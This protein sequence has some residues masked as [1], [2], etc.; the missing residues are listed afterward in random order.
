[1][2]Q[3]TSAFRFKDVSIG[4]KLAISTSL[5]MVIMLIVGGLGLVGMS[6]I[7]SNLDGI[8]TQQIAKVRIINAIR[9][10]YLTV[11][12]D[13]YQAVV[14]ADQA[15]VSQLLADFGRALNALDADTQTYLAMPHNAGEKQYVDFLKTN[16][17]TYMKNVKPLTQLSPAAFVSVLRPALS[18]KADQFY[19][20]FQAELDQ[21]LQSL[22]G[23]VSQI[24]NDSVNSFH[25]L[26]AVMVAVILAGAVISF[27]IGWSITRLIIRPLN[28]T[29][30]VIQAIAGG[31]LRPLG[32]FTSQ[33]GS[34]DAFGRLA[35][36]T[37]DMVEQLRSLLTNVR[38]TMQRFAETS[39]HITDA[40]Q[41]TTIATEQVAQTVQ[42]VAGDASHQ[43]RELDHV[44]QEVED[45][46]R[47][48]AESQVQAVSTAQ[49]MQT[50]NANNQSTAEIV[51][52]LGERS[53]EIGHIVETINEIA[54]QTNLLAL[55]AAIEAA[56]AGE[57]GRGFAVVA[58]EVRKLAERSASATKEISGIVREVQQSTRKTVEVIEGGV[59]EIQQGLDRTVAASQ[60]LEVIT[61]SSQA[62]NAAIAQVA[63]ISQQ[64]SASSE[65]VSAAIEEI[66][67][68]MME[69]SRATEQ[70][71]SATKEL[72]QSLAAF[73]FTD[74]PAARTT[75]AAPIPF[76]VSR[77]A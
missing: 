3:P 77:A 15:T 61:N 7:Q 63:T 75:G 43:S 13:V 25:Q 67:A 68:Q 51:R 19:V 30:S 52:G 22:N 23:Y 21:L 40:V 32:E 39:A 36:A 5:M 65:G 41:G 35:Y 45:L 66:T 27:L 11:S 42:T 73:R 17:P 1:M 18:G 16:V 50:I 6:R 60:Q 24:R 71:S 8:A 46:G 4:A 53:A 74:A 33:F 54:E 62:I 38:A 20:N 9:L 58:D 69:A 76:P 72:E 10:D 48:I 28:A 47:V 37:S 2:S 12:A 70:L 29:V 55:N 59:V 14:T 56:R 31:D 64:T 26:V 34:R 44:A 49:N 57:Q